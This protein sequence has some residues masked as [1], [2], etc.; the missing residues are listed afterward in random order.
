MQKLITH[1]TKYT[2]LYIKETK[3]FPRRKDLIFENF[4]NSELLRC[5]ILVY[6]PHTLAGGY[7]SFKETYCL[8]LKVE[9][10]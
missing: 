3:I 8:H 6:A 9:D 1:T 10:R 2:R 7:H 5:G 4:P